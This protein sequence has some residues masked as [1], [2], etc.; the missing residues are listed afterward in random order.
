FMVIW[1][2]VRSSGSVEVGVVISN[3][4]R[5]SRIEESTC[6]KDTESFSES[7]RTSARVS[8]VRACWAAMREVVNEL[9]G[10]EAS[11]KAWEPADQVAILAMETQNIAKV[12]SEVAVTKPRLS[13][14]RVTRQSHHC[15]R[16]RKNT[17]AKTP[18]SGTHRRDVRLP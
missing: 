9:Q 8:V 6:T 12:I 7:R 18:Q 13:R 16:S 5:A 10:L 11:S 17:A 1:V 3:S 4:S 15:A 14:R 2:M